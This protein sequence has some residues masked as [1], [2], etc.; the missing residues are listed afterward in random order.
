MNPPFGALHD[1]YLARSTN[2]TTYSTQ[3]VFVADTSGG[4]APNLSNIFGNLYSDSAGNYYAVWVG[5]LDD[6][7]VVSNPA[8]RYHIYLTTS[9]NKGATWSAPIVVDTLGNG[10]GLGTHTLVHFAVTSPG[11]I[12]VV[13]YGTPNVGEPNG[14]C[15]ST[16]MTHAC[17][18]TGTTSPGPDGMDFEPTSGATD[19]MNTGGPVPGN[20]KV[21]MAQSTNA[22]TATPSFT[23]SLIDPNYR[24]FG[25]ICTNGIVCG[26][27]SDRHLL[28]FISVAVD[29]TGA[30]HVTYSA[31][32]DTAIAPPLGDEG[33]EDGA[34][35]TVV[36]NQSGGTRIA[37]PATCP[38]SAVIPEAPLVPLLPL[39]VLIIG[40]VVAIARR[41]Q[42]GVEAA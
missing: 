4:K 1:Y 11:N 17:V 38:L 20:W 26:G 42:R 12:D 31:D 33:R 25:T 28:D 37:A 2:G 39:G 23:Y 29:C 22:L 14:V 18:D 7:T 34:R 16:G 27:A 6:N 8:N 5:T 36:T 19:G 40:G 13:Y 24:H 15:G 9:T 32:Q 35:E 21:Y 30:A 10:D 3:T 41:R